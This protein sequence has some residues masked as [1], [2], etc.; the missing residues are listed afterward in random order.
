MVCSGDK[1]VENCEQKFHVDMN[2]LAM[3]GLQVTTHILLIF[4][5]YFTVSGN[6]QV[7]NQALH[8]PKR[9]HGICSQASLPPV[10]IVCGPVSFHR[11]SLFREC[12]SVRAGKK[13]LSAE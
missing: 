5:P 3:S 1:S 10:Y 8:R 11:V 6:N 12:S 4:A 9:P 13:G 7:V 2:S